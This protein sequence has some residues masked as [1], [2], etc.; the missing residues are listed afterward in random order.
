MKLREKK[1]FYLLGKPREQTHLYKV[2]IK[3]KRY[4]LHSAPW[5]SP[6]LDERAMFNHGSLCLPC[7][8]FS[9][10]SCGNQRKDNL[11]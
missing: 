2:L 11:D 4:N 8:P 5:S 3:R 9:Q 6:L 10:S 1:E 7:T